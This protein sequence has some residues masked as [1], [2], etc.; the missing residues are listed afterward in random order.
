[1]VSAASCRITTAAKSTSS[2]LFQQDY[3][4]P[5]LKPQTTPGYWNFL[6]MVFDPARREPRIALRVRRLNDPV[7]HSPRGGGSVEISASGTG[8]LH[9]CRL[10]EIRTLPLADVRFT[11]LDGRPIRGVRSQADGTVPLSGL[12]A[13]PPETEVLM[14][15]HASG[16]VEARAIRTAPL[17]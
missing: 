6:E 1:M 11:M 17:G 7:G 3:E 4:S 12:V 13:V 9:S 16:K 15:A 5:D 2:P 10:P 14:T 8:R